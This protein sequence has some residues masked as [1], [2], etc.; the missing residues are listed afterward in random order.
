[1]T[2]ANEHT[3]HDAIRHLPQYNPPENIWENLAGSLDFPVDKLPEYAPPATIWDNIERSLPPVH[4]A[5]AFSIQR[6]WKPLAAAAVGLLLLV[7]TFFLSPA[8]SVESTIATRQETL[9]AVVSAT[10]QEPENPAFELVQNLCKEQQPVC[11]QPEF[12]ALKTD[13]D[14]LTAA[15][16]EIKSALGSYGNDTDLLA[17][18]VTIER[19]RTKV[20][21]QL[22]QMI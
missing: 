5:P 12:Q 19:E 4:T 13:L 17:Q 8:E 3:L 9:D 15:K 10:L 20:L 7:A 22:V 18:M 11:Q 6:Y 21:E 16:N 1:M 2:T 14:A